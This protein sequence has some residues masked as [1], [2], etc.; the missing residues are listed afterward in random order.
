MDGNEA[1]VERDAT[2]SKVDLVWTKGEDALA[3]IVAV[4]GFVKLCGSTVC[5]SDI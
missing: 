4:S 5:S 3:I 2:Q 1:G